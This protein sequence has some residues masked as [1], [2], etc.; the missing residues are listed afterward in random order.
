MRAA[1]LILPVIIFAVLSLCVG[2]NCFPD[3]I[4]AYN[5]DISIQNI[6]VL[7]AIEVLRVI[8]F[9]NAKYGNNN[10]ALIPQID[11][12]VGKL[13]KDKGEPSKSVRNYITALKMIKD[14]NS[15]AKTADEEERAN[16][17]I[18]KLL[19]DARDDELLRGHVP[20]VKKFWRLS[21][22]KQAN[23]GSRPNCA[24]TCINMLLSYYGISVE[25]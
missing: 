1:K 16:S 12:L 9:D 4:A 20:P 14:F 8:T 11:W 15:M 3:T 19:F 24:A 23:Q 2:G 21:I 25:S 6:K 18:R 13:E 22:A 17:D 5:E 7:T 10:N